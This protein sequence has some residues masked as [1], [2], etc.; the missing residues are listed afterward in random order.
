MVSLNGVMGGWHESA[1]LL[2]CT[3][4]PEHRFY[5]INL[6]CNSSW[7]LWGNSH[8]HM[9]ASRE[10]VTTSSEQVL[11]RRKS[12]LPNFDEETKA[13]KY[14][15]QS[16]REKGFSSPHKFPYPLDN[17]FTAYMIYRSNRLFKSY[18]FQKSTFSFK[19]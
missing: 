1:T 15:R 11:R 9:F 17:Y 8:S 19:L 13:R 16:F 3:R 10:T 4:L 18:K 2:W 5:V 12:L 7:D 6:C 14:R